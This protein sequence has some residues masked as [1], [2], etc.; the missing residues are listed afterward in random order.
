MKKSIALVALLVAFIS[1]NVNAKEI[2]QEQKMSEQKMDSKMTDHKMMKDHVFN[3]QCTSE[4]HL[5]MHGEK[6]HVCTSEC[7]KMEKEQ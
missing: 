7:M 2:K 6:G 3:A 4:K 5:Y 1:V